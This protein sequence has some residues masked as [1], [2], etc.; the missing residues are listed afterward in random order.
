MNLFAKA[1][2]E[3]RCLPLLLCF[4]RVIIQKKITVV[5]TKMQIFHTGG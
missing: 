4:L 3:L 5:N 2:G 1:G